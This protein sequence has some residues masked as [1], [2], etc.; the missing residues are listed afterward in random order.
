MDLERFLSMLGDC[1]R[2]LV[3]QHLNYTE[4]HVTDHGVAIST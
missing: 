1:E 3:L 2:V 4:L